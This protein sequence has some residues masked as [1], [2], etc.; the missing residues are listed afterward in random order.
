MSP[1]IRFVRFGRN[2]GKGL[3][4][5]W[6]A[7]AIISHFGWHYAICFGFPV[8]VPVHVH[9]PIP[10]PATVPISD[11]VPLPHRSPRPDKTCN[12][13]H[14]LDTIYSGRRAAQNEIDICTDWAQT[15]VIYPS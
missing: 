11:F 13:C 6:G 8:P 3:V 2:R 15:G 7:I 14:R 9:V 10:S 4:R 1:R 12:Q 5:F